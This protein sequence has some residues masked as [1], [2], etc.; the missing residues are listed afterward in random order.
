M[1]IFSPDVRGAIMLT[2]YGALWG[3]LIELIVT[4]ALKGTGCAKAKYRRVGPGPAL[5]ADLPWRGR[6]D[7]QFEQR[8]ERRPDVIEQAAAGRRA[9]GL[10]Y[11]VRAA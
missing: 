9:R 7:L 2:L 3:V 1:A 8:F 5:P 6:N 10:G 11:P 4:K